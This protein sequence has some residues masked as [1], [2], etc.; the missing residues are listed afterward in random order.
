[1]L[2]AL[3]KTPT[4]RAFLGTAL[5]APVRGQLEVLRGALIVVGSDGRI[6]AVHKAESPDTD[7]LVGDFAAAGRLV[8]LGPDQYLLPGL[9]DL[10]VHAPQWPQ[11]GKAL[12]LPL[13]EWLQAHTFPLEAR[14]AD[15]HYAQS[16]YESLVDGLLANGTTTALYFA[17]IHL[18]ATRILAD[19]CLR[20]SQR[21]LIGRVAMDDPR[22]CPS[23]YR[24]ASGQS[25]EAETRAFIAYVQSM[26]GND[27]ETIRPVITPRF[28]PSCSDDLL[29][30]LG[31]LA[32]ETGCHVQTHCSE[33]DWEHQ[34]VLHR[35][36]R[37][38][39]AA[40]DGW[41]LLS[42]RTILAHGN[43]ISDADIS[44]IAQRGAAIAHCPL[45]NVY[46]SDAVFPLQRVLKQGVHVGL[47]SDIAGGPSPSILDNARQAVIASR[48]LESGVDPTQ[49]RD[50][51]R[52]ADARIDATTAFW[53]A[54]AGGG[55]ALDLPVGVFREGFQFDALLIDA[56]APGSNLHIDHHDASQDIL[57]KIIYHCA[58][59]NISEVWVANRRVHS[60]GTSHILH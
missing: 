27:A 14:F 18:P 43:F 37:T 22:Q 46:F 51:R 50:Q 23:Y 42:R 36:G 1:M 45:S 58:R 40:L 13:E 34:F 17:S 9:V 10:H 33:S 8:T 2:N 53:L 44:L 11:L 19:I 5:H 55:I 48:T 32:Q 20:R 21:A 15:V 7:R 39:T 59:I 16:V 57:Q 35:C 41:G 4:E 3:S 60:L 28:I 29:R 38:D 25:A 31:R 56:R 49:R 12:E 24:D 6:D 47:G 52:N 54:T 26:P 30:R